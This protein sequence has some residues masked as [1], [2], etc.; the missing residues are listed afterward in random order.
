[1]KFSKKYMVLSLVMA[2]AAFA[3][4]SVSDAKGLNIFDK[5]KEKIGAGPSS[6]R[7]KVVNKKGEPKILANHKRYQIIDLGPGSGY[8]RARLY[9]ARMGGHLA[10]IRNYKESR[11]LYDFMI[12]QGYESAYFGLHDKDFNGNWRYEDGSAP[13]YL[14]WHYRQPDRSNANLKYA[15]LYKTYTAANWKAGTFSDI[16]K[17]KGDKAF[18]IEWDKVYD[19]KTLPSDV[20]VYVPDGVDYN[21]IQDP[22]PTPQPTYNESTG[23]YGYGSSSGSSGSY[24]EPASGG[25]GDDEDEEVV[26]F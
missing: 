4:P 9:A 16:D 6:K 21:K 3:T 7:I 8:L 11:M 22:E 20:S 23:S 1:M 25:S 10:V 18:I 13:K 17:V 26:S 2:F 15:M 24:E 5:M 14:N 19:E 12:S